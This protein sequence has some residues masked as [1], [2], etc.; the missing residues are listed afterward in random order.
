MKGDTMEAIN[1]TPLETIEFLTQKAQQCAKLAEHTK[2][3]IQAYHASYHQSPTFLN[4]P[5][6]SCRGT[7]AIL[8]EVTRPYERHA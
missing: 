6:A 8:Y 2:N 7:A 4:C 3:L 1:M 5:S